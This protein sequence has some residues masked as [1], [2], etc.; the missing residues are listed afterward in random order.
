LR[1]QCHCLLRRAGFAPAFAAF[2][3]CAATLAAAEPW[4]RQIDT[5]L[6]ESRVL[7]EAPPAD[8]AEFLR[9]AWITLAGGLPSSNEARAFL[10]DTAPD[11]RAKLID[12]LLGSTGWRATSGGCFSGAT[13]R[14]R[15]ATTTR[16]S[17]TTASAITTGFSHLWAGHTSFSPSRT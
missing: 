13:W 10:A 3:L 5:V 16:A 8:D 15:N 2:S 17:M 7:P 9:R 1:L 11:K 12:S 14:A 4:H 6:D